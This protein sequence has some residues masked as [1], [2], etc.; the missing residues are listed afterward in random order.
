M[1]SGI[2]DEGNMQVEKEGGTVNDTALSFARMAEPIN[3]AN[4]LS[5]SSATATRKIMS[6]GG[7]GVRNRVRGL[8][9]GG[10]M[11]RECSRCCR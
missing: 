11:A 4:I 9:G 10:L 2:V 8:R 1:L 6:G 5:T 7:V 3:V